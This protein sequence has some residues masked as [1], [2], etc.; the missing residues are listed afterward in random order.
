MTVIVLWLQCS[1]YKMNSVSILKHVCRYCCHFR[2]YLVPTNIFNKLEKTGSS[3]VF[4]LF[5]HVCGTW[6]NG[7]VCFCSNIVMCFMLICW[8]NCCLLHV[9]D[10]P[11]YSFSIVLCSIVGHY[12]RF[13]ANLSLVLCDGNGVHS[14]SCFYWWCLGTCRNCMFKTHWPMP[15]I[16]VEITIWCDLPLLSVWHPV[17]VVSP[18]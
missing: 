9:W 18:M 5:S 1:F 14:P 2:I 10:I 8:T 15:S 4:V 6:I 12:L 11:S 3:H 7:T 17:A 13:N 16:I